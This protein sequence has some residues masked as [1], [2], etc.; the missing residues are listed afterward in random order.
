MGLA[1]G[2]TAGPTAGLAVVPVVGVTA[3]LSAGFTVWALPQSLPWDAR[4]CSTAIFAG[5]TVAHPV[6]DSTQR[7]LPHLAATCLAIF[8]GHYYRGRCRETAKRMCIRAKRGGSF[9]ESTR[10]LDL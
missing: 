3:S 2:L 1:T 8:H 9:L 4:V 5:T 6:A 7:V 10:S